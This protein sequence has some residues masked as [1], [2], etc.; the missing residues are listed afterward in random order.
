M[1]VLRLY[2]DILRDGLRQPLI[3]LLRAALERVILEKIEFGTAQ[4]ERNHEQAIKDQQLQG[5]SA[6]QYF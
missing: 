5:Y 6:L 1:G 3:G 4:E 2:R